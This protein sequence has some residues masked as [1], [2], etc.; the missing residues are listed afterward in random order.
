M[1]V[2]RYFYPHPSAATEARRFVARM[3]LGL[4]SGDLELA[5]SELVT[6]AIRHARTIFTV[7]VGDVDDVVRLEVWDQSPVFPPSSVSEESPGLRI[8]DAIA[9]R[10]GAESTE[11]GKTVWAEF[12]LSP[13]QSEQ[14]RTDT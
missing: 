1:A 9:E 10:W 6:N 11:D 14:L 5:T 12:R 4:D 13:S 2:R 7:R 3:A 8:V